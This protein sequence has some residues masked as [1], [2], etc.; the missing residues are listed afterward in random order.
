MKTFNRVTYRASPRAFVSCSSRMAPTS[1]PAIRCS[2]SS[3]VR[4]VRPARGAV[5]DSSPSGSSSITCAR[6]RA[7]LQHE[8]LHRRCWDARIR[9]DAP[10][11]RQDVA[12]D[13]FDLGDRGTR[14]DDLAD[15]T[16]PSFSSPISITRRN[17]SEL[18]SK[19]FLSPGLDKAS[20]SRNLLSIFVAKN[21]AQLLSSFTLSSRVALGNQWPSF[22]DKDSNLDKKLQDPSCHWTIPRGASHDSAETADHATLRACQV[23]ANWFRFAAH[24]GGVAQG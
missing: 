19:Y 13:V 12:L 16:L 8:D 15:P 14:L 9:R 23:T 4:D 24:S 3:S 21:R 1:M 22:G 6:G 11:D 18:P 20:P 10:Q 7:A 5:R 2:R 17:S